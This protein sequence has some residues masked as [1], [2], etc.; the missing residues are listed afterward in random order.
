MF[1]VTTASQLTTTGGSI[2]GGQVSGH[3]LRNVRTSLAIRLL[4]SSV[5]FGS[6]KSIDVARAYGSK[7]GSAITQIIK[8]LESEAAVRRALSPDAMAGERGFSDHDDRS[9]KKIKIFLA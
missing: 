7:D 6:E 5:R 3:T 4:F 9:V 8:R 1:R 2:K